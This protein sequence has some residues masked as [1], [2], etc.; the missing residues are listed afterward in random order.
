[1]ETPIGETLEPFAEVFGEEVEGKPE[2]EVSP[3]NRR[4]HIDGYNAGAELTN[5]LHGVTLIFKQRPGLI[6]GGNPLR[7]R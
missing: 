3:T 1:M 7:D 2:A 6:D 4:H 5:D